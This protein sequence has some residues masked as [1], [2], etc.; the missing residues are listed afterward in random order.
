MVKFSLLLSYRGL[1]RSWESS[2]LA[3]LNS[4]TQLKLEKAAKVIQETRGGGVVYVQGDGAILL[5]TLWNEGEGL[6]DFVG[7]SF[8]DY[9]SGKMDKDTQTLSLKPN[10]FT[11]IYDIGDESALNKQ[12]SG[13]LLKQLI[14]QCRNDKVW[15]FICGDT[16]KTKFTQEYGLDIKNSITLPTK[17]ETKLI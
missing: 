11:F 9:F 5:S 3:E 7:L 1:P 8:P 16:T 10:R 15:C 13:Q 14:T 6:K 4:A 2:G 12:F 17:T